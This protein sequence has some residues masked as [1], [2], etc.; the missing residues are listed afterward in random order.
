MDV[1]AHICAATQAIGISSIGERLPFAGEIIKSTE[2]N[3]NTAILSMTI[4]QVAQTST[5]HPLCFVDKFFESTEN[6][7]LT[8]SLKYKSANCLLHNANSKK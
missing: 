5:R 8:K 6:T 4:T 7:L 2:S 1:S 3:H